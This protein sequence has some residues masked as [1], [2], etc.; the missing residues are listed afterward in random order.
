MKKQWLE[1]YYQ[2]ALLRMF[3]FPFEGAEFLEFFK[4]QGI[5]Q[6]WKQSSWAVLGGGEKT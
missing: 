4:I 5:P 6:I 3:V 1:I 2:F